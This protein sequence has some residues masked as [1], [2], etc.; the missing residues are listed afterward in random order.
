MTRSRIEIDNLFREILESTNVYFQPPE[1]VKMKYPCIRYRL[2]DY[3]SDFAN[4]KPYKHEKSY[5][6]TIISKNADSDLIEKVLKLEKC[7]FDRFYTADNL[8]HWVF[9][10]YS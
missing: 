9:I 4:N 1:S 5:I 10:I 7:H 2:N 3:N 8:Y 6:G